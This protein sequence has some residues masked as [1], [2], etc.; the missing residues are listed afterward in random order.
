MISKVFFYQRIIHLNI[1]SVQY[2]SAQIL[3]YKI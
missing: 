1:H 3:K 2:P